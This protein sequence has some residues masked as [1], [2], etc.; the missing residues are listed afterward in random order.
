MF[1]HISK[2]GTRPPLQDLKGGG[3]RPHGDSTSTQGSQRA[4][5]EETERDKRI[6]LEKVVGGCS[7]FP[8]PSPRREALRVPL[9]EVDLSSL[10]LGGQRGQVLSPPLRNVRQDYTAV[11]LV[12]EQRHVAVLGAVLPTIGES[13]MFLWTRSGSLR[14][15]LAKGFF[16]KDFF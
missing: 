10:K 5:T 2:W 7:N 12:A 1:S 3:L 9:R 8:S 13:F 14:W 11:C 6:S 15:E 4:E 16:W